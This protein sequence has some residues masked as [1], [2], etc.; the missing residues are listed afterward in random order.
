MSESTTGERFP[1]PN[2]NAIISQ[3]AIR[4]I[5]EEKLVNEIRGIYEGLVMVEKKCLEIDQQSRFS[6]DLSSTQWKALISL[7]RTLLHEHHDF[8]LASQQL[9]DSPNLRQLPAKYSIR[10]RMWRHGIHSFFE[11]LSQRLPTTTD[12]LLPFIHLAYSLMSSHGEAA[13]AFEDTWIECLGDVA[14]CRMATEHIETSDRKAWAAVAP[15]WYHKAH[16]RT[17][18]VRHD[19]AD[20]ER[21]HIL[22]KLFFSI[23][24]LA[25]MAYARNIIS[26]F[27]FFIGL[28]SCPEPC[29]R[30]NISLPEDYHH[31]GKRW[32]YLT[33]STGEAWATNKMDLEYNVCYS[34][35]GF[36][37]RPALDLF[38]ALLAF[39]PRFVFAK[40][41]ETRDVVGTVYKSI[42]QGRR[43]IASAVLWL[44]IRPKSASFLTFSMLLSYSSALPIN[45]G[46]EIKGDRNDSYRLRADDIVLISFAALCVPVCFLLGQRLGQPRTFGTLMVVFNIVNLMTSGDPLVSKVGHWVYFRR[47]AGKT[48]PSHYAEFCSY[49][50]ISLSGLDSELSPE[51]ELRAW[52]I[53]GREIRLCL[54]LSPFISGFHIDLLVEDRRVVGSN[55]ARRGDKHYESYA[56]RHEPLTSQLKQA[57]RTSA[58]FLEH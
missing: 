4:P 30:S 38:R 42:S 37:S 3:P 23:K 43:A 49:H 8:F 22:Q 9:S 18:R 46:E 26:R 41:A 16:G 11:T 56:D 40:S 50:S 20:L 48:L 45:Q 34:I 36:R 29:Q 55:F 31:T 25:D 32:V 10:A 21:P 47:T 2:Y 13:S 58:I 24:S 15:Y 14:R 44:P 7:H 19:L 6:S 1:N 39:L 28:L 27:P 35:N 53:W 54:S 51:P 17:H 12:H 57:I 52:R 33:N 5:S